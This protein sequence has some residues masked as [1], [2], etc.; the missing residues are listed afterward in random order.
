MR[1]LPLKTGSILLLA[2]VTACGPHTGGTDAGPGDVRN[3]RYC[4]ILVG[5]ISGNNVHI[6]VYNTQGLNDCPEDQWSAVST[7][8]VMTQ[9]SADVVLLNGPR[10]WMIDSF[11][12]SMLLNNTPTNVGGIEM[13]QAGAIDTTVGALP[14]MESAYALHTVDRD[15]EFIWESG[16]PAYQL[17]DPQGHVYTM[18][19]YS[20]AKDPQ[21]TIDTLPDLGAA[22]TLPSGW[23]FRVVTLSQE[24]DL[25]SHGRHVGGGAPVALEEEIPV[26]VLAARIHAARIRGGVRGVP[27]QQHAG[28]LVRGSDHGG[29]R[30][31]QCDETGESPLVNER[32]GGSVGI[33]GVRGIKCGR[34]VAA[35]AIVIRGER[36]GG[37][38]ELFQGQQDQA[39]PCGI[40][41]DGE[42]NVLRGR[43][44]E[45]PGQVSRDVS[46]MGSFILRPRDRRALNGRLRDGCRGARRLAPDP[47]GSASAGAGTAVEGRRVA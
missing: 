9:L 23:M 16:K 2:F 29:V 28:R 30:I 45:L 36:S 20:L 32:L 44:T 39:R 19:S 17:I 47:T 12:Q 46:V 35:D 11:G 8:Q 40:E 42:S 6:E 10:Y 3:T 31:R 27:A 41:E 15:S 24:I 33:A 26:R 25:V 37:E 21:Q 38:L 4:E 7:Q 5:F 14:G 43:G 1:T 13:R 18:Q 34:V 22:L